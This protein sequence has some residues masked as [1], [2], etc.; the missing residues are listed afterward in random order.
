MDFTIKSTVVACF[1]S[2]LKHLAFQCVSSF[3]NLIVCIDYDEHF[4]RDVGSNLRC[5][6]ILVLFLGGS[7]FDIVVTCCF[8][9]F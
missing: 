6:L 5:V 1:V 9:A 3:S 4:G 2:L 8:C 7:F